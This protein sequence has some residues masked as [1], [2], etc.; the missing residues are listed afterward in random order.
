MAHVELLF[1]RRRHPGS[2]LI[3]A[4]TWSAFSHV[5]LIVGN[6][7]IGAQ[8][9]EGVVRSARCYRLERASRAA[10]M[11]IAHP[12]PERVQEL[13]ESQ[14]GK[15]YDWA[16]VVGL[17]LRRRWQDADCWFCSELIAWAFEAS[18]HPLFRAAAAHRITPQ[19]LWLLPHPC[20]WQKG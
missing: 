4:L 10:I 1:T 6:E 7:V 20:E 8:A 13:V 3:R 15:P 17:G 14:L 12:H 9:P 18:G 16:G 2:A 11:R 19:H 5:E